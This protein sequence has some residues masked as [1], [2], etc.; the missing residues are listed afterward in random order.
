MLWTI[1]IIILVVWLV[2][3]LLTSFGSGLIHLLLV[4]AAIVLLFQLLSGRRAL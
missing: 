4:L 1:L 2:A 3:N